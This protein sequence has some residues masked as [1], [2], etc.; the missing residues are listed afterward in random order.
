MSSLIHRSKQALAALSTFASIAALLALVA[1]PATAAAAPSEP[2]ALS[3]APGSYDFG[4]QPVNS[5]PAQTTLQLRNDG[6]EGV[7]IESL[8][9]TG[10]GSESF[11]IGSSNCWGAF[12]E[13]TQTCSI[14]VNFGPR[15]VAEYAVQL[16]ASANSTQFNASLSG[17]G[18]SPHFVPDSNSVDFGVAKV[19]AAGNTREI[20]VTN[21][22]NW[23]GGVFIAVIS[24][25]AVG[26][27]QLLDE[28]CTGRELVPSATCTLQVRFRPIAEGV[29]KATLSLFGESDGGTQ[30]ILT[31]VGAAPDPEAGPSTSSGQAASVAAT[32]DRAAHRPN[33]EKAKR[34]RARAHR[35]HH[36]RARVY[37]A[38]LVVHGGSGKREGR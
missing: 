11:W 31:G 9:I 33:V 7:P 24:G 10:S 3:F 25:G 22:G 34:H 17:S 4:L 1:L 14:Q 26:S 30:I 12:L 18:A 8:S 5:N 16:Q 6:A 37:K 20:T 28:N 15:N 38:R 29:K 19:G 36:R 32:V 35:R 21:V 23:P 27:Y 2:A 13:P